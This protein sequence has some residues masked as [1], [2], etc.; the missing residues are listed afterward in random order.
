SFYPS[1]IPAFARQR[2]RRIILRLPGHSKLEIGRHI[3]TI[4]ALALANLSASWPPMSEQHA[5]RLNSFVGRGRELS[6][7]DAALADAL[8]CH[9]RLVLVSGETGIGKTRLADEA[10]RHAAD[11]GLN[12][13]WGRCWEGVGAPPYWPLI[14]VIRSLVARNEFASAISFISHENLLRV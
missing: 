13:I 10:S 11:L 6:H 2:L 1:E 4:V 14:Q 8:T 12:V 7:I 9:G 5:I 3:D